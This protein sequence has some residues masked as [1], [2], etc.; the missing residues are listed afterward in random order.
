MKLLT[1][2]CAALG[3]VGAFAQQCNRDIE[4]LSSH[5]QITFIGQIISKDTTNVKNF[6]ASVKPLC[7]MYGNSG[8]ITQEEFSRTIT[9][10]GFGNHAGGSCDAA[11][12]NVGDIDIFFVH[13][14][15]TVAA[16]GVR[17]FGL[18]D[19]CYGAFKNETTSYV[20]L[21]K[22]AVKNG[23]TPNGVQCPVIVQQADGINIDGTTYPNPIN[24]DEDT[25]NSGKVSLDD[26]SNDAPKAI[27]M[28]SFAFVVLAS[29][30]QYLF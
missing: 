11:I 24:L 28:T 3:A 16:G 12:S 18:Y 23:Y 15:N 21:T 29:L 1:L 19:P 20:E 27:A 5:A 17:T 25:T 9:I 4:C 6:S 8:A 14:N 10:S 13:V 26:E 30:L 7:N 22:L 2:A